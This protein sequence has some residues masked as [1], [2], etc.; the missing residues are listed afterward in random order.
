MVAF[1]IT[2]APE[3]FH[4]RMTEYLGDIEGMVLC[5]VDDILVRFTIPR[6]H[7]SLLTVLGG[8]IC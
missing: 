2:S 7:L 6:N 5:L 4:S 3:H 8:F 1:G